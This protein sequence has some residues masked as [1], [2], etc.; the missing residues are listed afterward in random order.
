MV[1]SDEKNSKASSHHKIVIDKREHTSI[2]GVVDVISFDESTIITET[3]QGALV[4]KGI[5]L[6]IS[7]LNLDVGQL[8][9]DG[10]INSLIYQENAGRNKGSLFSKIFK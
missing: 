2:G 4:I 6:H 1:I 7:N 9:I 5:N 10:I 8:E 3:E